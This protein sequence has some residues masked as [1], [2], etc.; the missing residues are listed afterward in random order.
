MK[1]K[2]QRGESALTLW[3]NLNEFQRELEWRRCFEVMD[4]E[5]CLYFFRNYWTI[6]TAKGR[7]FFDP[8]EAQIDTLKIWMNDPESITLK[9]RQI[10]FSTLA[11][12]LSCWLIMC[13]SDYEVLTL[14]RNGREAKKQLRERVKYG[15]LDLPP[16]MRGRFKVTSDTI[17]LFALDNGSSVV[18][19]PSNNPARGYTSRKIFVDEFAF[20]EK[21]EDAAAAIE[22]AADLGGAIHYLSTANGVGNAFHAMWVRAT[23][24]KNSGITPIF[25]SWAA[26]GRDQAWYDAKARKLP[27]WQLHQEYPSSAEEAFIKSGRPVF[28]VLTFEGIDICEPI[29][30]GYLVEGATERTPRLIDEAEGE[31]WIWRMPELGHKYVIGADVAEGLEWGDWSVAYVIDVN[32]GDIV[33]R[34]FGHTDPDTFGETV[35]WNL[36]CFYHMALIGPEVNNH[37]YTTCQALKRR[38]YPNTYK[39]FGF[40]EKK[41]RQRQAL[42]WETNAATKRLLIDELRMA[43]RDN[44]ITLHDDELGGDFGELRTFV[45]DTGGKLHGSPHDDRV[46]ALGIANQ[47]RKHWFATRA[48]D[49]AKQIAGTFMELELRLE[50]D[51]DIRQMRQ[52]LIGQYSVR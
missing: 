7:K 43:L 4:I 24:T 34:W 8:F 40:N 50:A 39:R 51:F 9:A 16:A 18:S 22:P 29:R 44:D 26:N 21:A 13:E 15:W 14:S 33:A 47:L 5:H 31:V 42:G 3:D 17:E 27:E 12:A 11:G 38:F 37:G 19:L 10:G 52:G 45:R 30:K 36:G 35:L 28:D 6:K 25:Y 46:M 41:D 23:T 32:D 2:V 20:M 1:A 49:E 48:E